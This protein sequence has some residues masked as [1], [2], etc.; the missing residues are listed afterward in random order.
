[1]PERRP[2]RSGHVGR[3]PLAAYRAPALAFEF[4]AGRCPQFL[5]GLGRPARDSLPELGLLRL[6]QWV[7]MF[8]LRH[9]DV[10]ERAD[11]FVLA[12]SHMDFLE[13]VIRWLNIKAVFLNQLSNAVAWHAT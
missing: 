2:A 5:L 4:P 9:L 12:A 13:V 10:L 8:R 1:M 11:Q 6:E 7:S 3:I